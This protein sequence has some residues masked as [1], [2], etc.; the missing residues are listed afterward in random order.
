VPHDAQPLEGGAA[1]HHHTEPGGRPD[2]RHHRDRHGDRDGARGGGDEHDQRPGDPQLRVPEQRAEPRHHDGHDDD[3]GHQRLGD[4]VRQPGPVTL[5]RLRLLDQPDDRGQRVVRTG[6]GGLHPQHRTAVHRPREDLVT[7]RDVHR[8]GLTGHRGGVHD[9]DAGPHHA[10]GRH[11]LPGPHDEHVPRLQVHRPDA[12]RDAVPLDGGGRRDQ[13]QQRPQTATGAVHRLVLQR[14]GDGVEE[15]QRGR[16][17]DVAEQHGTDRADR[18]EHRDAELAAQQLA[19]RARDEGG[20]ADDHGAPGQHQRHDVR[21][22]GGLADQPG[23][24]EHARCDR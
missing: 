15:G 12:H 19:Q 13:R 5:A 17:L 2:G 9:S 20:P 8:H 4:P 7:G 23:E 1:L 18:H 24:Q 11:P 22:T 16:L 3:A 6:G 10:V 14:L 21:Y